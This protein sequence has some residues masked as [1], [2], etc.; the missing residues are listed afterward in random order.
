[1]SGS[2]IQVTPECTTAFNELNQNRKYKYIIFKLAENKS[3][4][5]KKAIRNDKPQYNQIVVDE[6]SEDDKDWESF[7]EKLINS[8]EVIKGTV[9][10]SPRY[11]V[12]DLEWEHVEAS[13]KSTRQKPVF[14]AWSPDDG[15]PVMLRTVYSSSKGAL[16]NALGFVTELQANDP[17]DV[18]FGNAKKTVDR[19]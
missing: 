6:A 5:E 7:R 12:Y 16:K 11:A 18:T 2:G 4:E 17:D 1:M 13:G 14:I 19:N 3:P 15:C 8:T 9:H 10:K